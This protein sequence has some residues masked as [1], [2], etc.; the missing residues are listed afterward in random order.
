MKKFLCLFAILFAALF[1][2]V[3]CTQLGEDNGVESE[4]PTV[5]DTETVEET[6]SQT[7]KPP[8]KYD[9]Y[10][11]QAPDTDDDGD[12]EDDDGDTEDD[13]GADTNADT[14]NEPNSGVGDIF[15]WSEGTQISG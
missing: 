6:E 9:K 14:K 10:D 15:D 12:T 13:D 5:F 7:K 8:N 1:A 4:S 11:T 3:S 2:I